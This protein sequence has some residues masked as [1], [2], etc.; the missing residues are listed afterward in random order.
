MAE[1][2]TPRATDYSQWYIDIVIN[3]KLADYAPVKGCMVIRPRGYALWERIQQGMDGLFKETGHVNAYFPLLIPDSFLKKEAEHVEGFSP[4]L[5][6]VTHAGG[7]KLE[8]PLVIRP[9]SET[10]IWSMYKKWIQS[11][12]DLPL[13]INQ[14][15]NVLRWEKRTRLFLR[16]TEF[17][18]QE[19]HTAHA[20]SAEA[21]EETLRMLEVYRKFAEEYLA[22]PVLHGVK[23][24]SEKFAGAVRTYCI[25]AMMQDRKAL[26]AGT[27]HFLGQNFAKAF[28][29][30]FQTR[31]KTLDHVWATSWGASTRLIG[32]LIMTH[33]DDKGL[34]LPPRIAPTEV[35]I[36]PIFKNDTKDAVVAFT[37]KLRDSLAPGFR[38]V[39]DDDDQNTPGWKFSE[40]ELQGVP[41]RVEAGP[42]DMEKGQVVAVRRDTGEKIPV[43]VAEAP[44]RFR[45]LLDDIQASLYARALKYRTENTFRAGSYAEL[46]RLLDEPGG[47]IEAGWCGSAACE[48]KV[49]EETKATIRLLPFGK[50][51]KETGGAACVVCG[52]PAQAIAVFARAY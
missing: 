51:K 24:D 23:T 39:L 10:I 44:A 17:L 28:D 46:S 21:E 14:W 40:Y 2:I 5:A 7:E 32:A 16:T 52:K 13:L 4:E 20:T 31:D 50:D 25:E 36:V 19:G 3:A 37:R 26:Q 22:I 42:R 8:E 38:V 34:V 9:T 49:K 18:W 43:P 33:S 11:Y 48:A 41:L 47:F 12:R 27:S 29:V 1:K 30:T 15:C 35:V 6:V 45:A